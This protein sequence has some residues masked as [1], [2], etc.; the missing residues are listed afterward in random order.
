MNAFQ[1]LM[2]DCVVLR[3]RVEA[4]EKETEAV[5]AIATNLCAKCTQ[6]TLR[7]MR[8]HPESVELLRPMLT[9]LQETIARMASRIQ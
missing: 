7:T 3:E 1:E 5:Q 6:L 8:E 2:A 4:L 9:E